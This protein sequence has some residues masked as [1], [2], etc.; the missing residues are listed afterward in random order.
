MRCEMDIAYLIN[1]LDITRKNFDAIM[2]AP[3][4]SI[5]DF[6]NYEDWRAFQLSS[7]PT[8]SSVPHGAAARGK[9]RYAAKALMSCVTRSSPLA[10]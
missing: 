3:L 1:K 8:E 6:K 5:G 9:C 4:R 2:T 7:G 10:L